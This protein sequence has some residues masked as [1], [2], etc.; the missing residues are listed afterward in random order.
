MK[1]LLFS[2]IFFLF[3]YSSF[4]VPCYMGDPT[5]TACINYDAVTGKTTVKVSHF[6]PP[7]TPWLTNC[8]YSYWY[9]APL[10]T[11]L[12]VK[13][14]SG[15]GFFGPFKITTNVPHDPS[16]GAAYTYY[17][18]TIPGFSTQ[19][20]YEVYIITNASWSAFDPYN[21]WG[22]T[23]APGL[24]PSLPNCTNY[25][26]TPLGVPACIYSTE[27]A[28]LA[29]VCE[30]SDLMTP[31]NSHFKLNLFVNSRPSS[32]APPGFPAMMYLNGGSITMH[33][34]NPSSSYTYQWDG[35]T[36]PASV[37][38]LPG[39]FPHGLAPGTHTVC[40]TEHNSDGSTCKTCMT[41]CVPE[42]ATEDSTGGG[43][44]MM[45]T[46]PND[47]SNKKY[48]MELYPNPATG[49]AGVKFVLE[50]SE[51]VSGGVFDIS[52][53]QI[54]EFPASTMSGGA[55][56]V[57]FNTLSLSPGVYQVYLRIGEKAQTK[58]LVI[59]R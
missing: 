51:I 44:S 59:Q 54:I 4:A 46:A 40:V 20:C 39:F 31:C 47:E 10:I 55:Q 27:N 56:K 6:A 45:R 12:Y 36:G 35:V 21:S 24:D 3:G 5:S 22:Y 26:S 19:Q 29:C 25:W 18:V 41:F 9:A 33:E 50:K 49:K 17:D 23:P 30:G 14:P 58:K 48:E 13:N 34:F 57:E 52:G 32:V 2:L 42:Y 16:V 53:K 11:W 43:G 28:M 38:S 7:T 1:K 15:P 37:P 8:S